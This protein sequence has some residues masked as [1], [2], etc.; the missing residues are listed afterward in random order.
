MRKRRSV[1][2]ALGAGT[3][4][5]MTGVVSGKEQNVRVVVELRELGKGLNK[6]QMIAA[7]KREFAS[8]VKGEQAVLG[9]AEAKD[10]KEVVGFVVGVNKDGETRRF[11]GTTSDDTQ[12][13][14]VHSDAQ[15]YAAQFRE[16]WLC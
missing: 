1:L 14:D 12:V 11:V 9:A 3:G 8:F 7:Q 10:E 2:K 15:K 6:G 5:G 16:E 13:S 4:L